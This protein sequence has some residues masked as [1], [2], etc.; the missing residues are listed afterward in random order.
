MDC[1]GEFFLSP[2]SLTDIFPALDVAQ[3]EHIHTVFSLA[4]VEVC[5]DLFKSKGQGI[6]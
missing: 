3:I 5:F 1:A 6:F 4:D 2:A